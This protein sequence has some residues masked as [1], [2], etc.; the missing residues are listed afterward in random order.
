MLI[1]FVGCAGA[2][3][4]T[5]IRDMIAAQPEKFDILQ[6]LTTRKM[7]DNEKQGDPYY[8]V[9]REDFERLLEQGM[10][11]EHQFVHKDFYGGSR[12]VLEDK[13]KTGKTLLKDIDI[14]GAETYKKTLSDRLPVLSLFL[15]VDK[16][17][18]LRRLRE[19][20]DREEDIEMRSRRFDMEI[21]LSENM[22]YMIN[23]ISREDT[24]NIIRAMIEAEK[25]GT[26]YAAATV[27]APADEEAIARAEARIQSGE[28]P[29]PVQ[30]G[31]NGT[32]ILIIEGA[33]RY[34]AAL[35][36]H[37]FIQKKFVSVADTSL[38]RA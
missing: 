25:T 27:C 31:F 20:G 13:I 22:D 38:K 28:K 10:I 21:G 1:T 7:R 5:I 2:G 19:R 8:F 4:N 29:A 16:Q 32:E 23:N 17:E 24:A 37:T 11:Y 35:R 34:E 3:K 30:M 9:S 26:R 6:T 15:Y 18:L 33:D 36:T 14:L 12:L